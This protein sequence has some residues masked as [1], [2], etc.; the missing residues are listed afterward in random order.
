M[1][2][3]KCNKELIQEKEVE[4]LKHNAW[5]FAAALSVI[6]HH[7]LYG[8]F[9]AEVLRLCGQTEVSNEFFRELRGPAHD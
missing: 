9:S 4:A 1:T 5:L 8:E 2:H 3:I 7:G 6:E